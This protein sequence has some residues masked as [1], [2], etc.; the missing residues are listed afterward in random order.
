MKKYLLSL[1]LILY[2]LLTAPLYAVDKWS[3]DDTDNFP[4]QPILVYDNSQTYINPFEMTS[5]SVGKMGTWYHQNIN[6][7][8]QKRH[9]GTADI[10][11]LTST[12]KWEMPFYDKTKSIGLDLSFFTESNQEIYG[13]QSSD[14]R[15][16]FLGL[17]ALDLL[18]TYKLKWPVRTP[19]GD[20][21][22][23]ISAKLGPIL[24]LSEIHEVDHE[25][26]LSSM[27][28]GG[29]LGGSVGV[30]YYPSQW[31]GIFFEY[32]LKYNY[33][34]ISPQPQPRYGYFNSASTIGFKTTF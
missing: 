1:L 3:N 22:P 4:I 8:F 13:A 29:V 11:N 33:I 23:N 5:F 34:F 6:G 7:I 24:I 14:E 9:W 17:I 30:D 25:P 27:N 31:F 15:Q 21:A 18:G 20:I 19:I 2:S 28:I 16:R 10:L 32:T 12:A 26:R